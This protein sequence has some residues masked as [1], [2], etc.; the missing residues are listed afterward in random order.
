M[1]TVYCGPYADAIGDDHEG[2]AARLLP[3]GT[4]TGIWT[5]ETREF[6]GYCARCECG[7]R[8]VVVHPPT[9]AGEDAA[10]DEWDRN[11]LRLLVRAE[12]RRHVVSAAVL[13][14]FASELRDALTWTVDSRGAKKLTGR[15][16]GLVDAAERLE[17]LLD[18]LGSRA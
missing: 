14:D 6:H 4:E 11:H 8:G 10:L 3:D 1:G 16:R 5:Y 15:S 18:D 17:H 2:Y 12:A 9:D 13:L 7:W